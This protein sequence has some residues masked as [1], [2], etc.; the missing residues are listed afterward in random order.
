MS[1]TI[2][3]LLSDK[4]YPPKVQEILRRAVAGDRTVGPELQEVFEEYP[5][6]AETFGDMARHAELSLL[7]LI[8][9][10]DQMLR[11]A[12]THQVAAL[13]G[14]L[15][16]TASSELENLLIDRICISWME[17]YQGDIA[18]AD[19]QRS[20][21]G[22]SPFAKAAQVRLDRAHQRY[23]SSVKALE[24]MQRLARPASSPAG[25]PLR[26]VS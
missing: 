6:F 13:R 17:V 16:A 11:E 24:T 21:S 25:P 9:G 12:I 14:R 7:N 8:A 2:Q 4:N 26:V 20:G 10:P 1:R 23:L 18:M 3:E 19:Y 22:A 5:E 15:A